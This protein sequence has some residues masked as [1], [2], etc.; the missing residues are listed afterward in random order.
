MR[1]I[2][3]RYWD[4]N[5]KRMDQNVNF[6]GQV[7]KTGE[8]VYMQ[9]TGLLDKNK[10]PIYEGDILSWL[11]E[12]EGLGEIYEVYYDTKTASFRTKCKGVDDNAW[13][14]TGMAE[15]VITDEI[16]VIGNIYKNPELL[17]PHPKKEEER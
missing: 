12:E 8:G 1:Q 2:K 16:E 9:F 15:D 4:K 5:Y 6:L 13:F 11:S 3:F 17:S 10:K 14:N 7:E